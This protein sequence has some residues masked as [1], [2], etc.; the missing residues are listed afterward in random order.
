[1]E[2][3]NKTKD[4]SKKGLREGAGVST[5]KKRSEEK[6]AD[7]VDGWEVKA[8]ERLWSV[9]AKIRDAAIMDVHKACAAL[10]A[11]EKK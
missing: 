10:K 3:V 6:R 4:C 5:S 7:R 9:P 8:P 11:K 2:H 1:V